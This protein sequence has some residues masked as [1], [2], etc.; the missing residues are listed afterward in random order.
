MFHCELQYALFIFKFYFTHAKEEQKEKTLGRFAFFFISV[1]GKRPWA[2]L[3]CI[4]KI[5][6]QRSVND[7]KEKKRKM[8]KRSSF[9]LFDENLLTARSSTSPPA[10]RILNENTL[11]VQCIIIIIFILF[12]YGFSRNNIITL[13][14]SLWYN[15][16]LP[17]WYTRYTKH[18]IQN[19]T[20]L[21]FIMRIYVNSRC[22]CK[23]S[24]YEFF[25]R[26]AEIQFKYNSMA[27]HYFVRYN[28]DK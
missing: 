9:P 19:N 5:P 28:Y 7:A 8:K 12:S 4:E 20:V 21:H 18:N 26:A 1:I 24:E 22:C 15:I 25:F 6:S 27:I 17:S 14:F 10:K 3:Y 23:R 2:L 13:S 16:G 11:L